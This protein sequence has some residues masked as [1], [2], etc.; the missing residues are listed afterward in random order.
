VLLSFL[1][2]HAMLTWREVHRA[3]LSKVN[4]PLPLALGGLL[5]SLSVLIHA[6]GA[7]SYE[8]WAWN[9]RQGVIDAHPGRVWDW[10]QPQSLAGW[11]EMPLPHD[12]PLAEPLIDL[13]TQESDKYLL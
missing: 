11:I 6:R 8:T 3:Q 7:I 1:G 12:F 4:W 2:V 9:L 13:R 10:R 5:L